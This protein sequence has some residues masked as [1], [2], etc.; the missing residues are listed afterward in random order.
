MSK[1]VIVTGVSG[2][3]GSYMSDY[4]LENTEHDV[5]GVVRRAAKPDYGN[6][7]KAL[8]NPRFKLVTA[9]LSDSAS[10][11]KIVQDIR[12]DYFINFAAQ[13]FVK[14]SWDVPEQTMDVNA[15]GTMRCL[16]AIKTFA[17]T[18]RFY[19]AGSSEEFGDVQYSPQ[20]EK[21]PLR[22]RSPYGAS[23]I[24]A[25]QIVKTY[26][27]SYNLYAVQGILFNHE[28]ER[29]GEEFVTRK[30]TKGVA[31]IKV[32]LDKGED[33]DPI[34]LGNLESKRDWSHAED[35]VDGIWR[36]LNQE[37]FNPALKE[38]DIIQY[39][40]AI[41]HDDIRAF[42]LRIVPKLKDY[43]LSSNETHTISEFVKKAFETIGIMGYWDWDEQI[44]AGIPQHTTYEFIDVSHKRNVVLVK[45]NPKFFRPAEI[46]L[47][48]GDSS[49]AR[50]ELG[51][52]PK[53][54]FDNLVKRMVSL[55]LHEANQAKKTQ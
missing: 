25:R 32:A 7:K 22:A 13:S 16:E 43:V 55:D 24:A 54:S 45:I 37:K 19:N 34:E 26:R 29:R 3:D 28:S 41:T 18:C 9:D 40:N 8:E 10:I 31:R 49:A 50:K 17:P 51:W 23:K 52:T 14:A 47:L 44:N 11:N 20:D 2:Q 42:Y 15:T 5:Y 27:D 33:F 53:I 39:T 4:L 35:F 12:P 36:M 48:L 6:L 38:F 46:D 1:K 30:I 21:H